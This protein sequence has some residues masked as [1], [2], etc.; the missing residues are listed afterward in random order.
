MKCQICGFEGKSL[1]SH[2]KKHNISVDE[3]KRKYNVEKVHTVPESQKKY[4][5][6]L[7]KNRM[8][9]KKWKDKFSKSRVSI[10]D[11]KYWIQ[12]GMEESDAIDMVKKIQSDNA[13]KRDYSKSP[14]VLSKEFYLSKG[15]TI[16]E[17]EKAISEI[18][19]KL[20]SNSSKFSGK[21]HSQK[22][23][24]KISQSIS[25]HIHKIG[26]S[27]WVS[28]FGDLSE[29]KYKSNGEIEIFNYVNNITENCVEAN[30]FIENYNVDLLYKNKIIDYFGVYW[31]CHP[32]FYKDDYFHRQKNKFAY[33]IRDEDNKRI[34]LLQEMGYSVMIVWENDYIKNKSETL[35]KVK[36]F[37]YDS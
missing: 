29:P 7:W 10:W 32:D 23:K 14:T 34:D 20:S 26:V 18:Q 15:F 2:L 5:S 19:S 37:I 1:V 36:Q 6:D 25:T 12:K 11:Y 24:E 31:H 16:E 22:S 4:L 9:D 8:K 3:Y 30:V 17:A 27:D 35:N 21:K 13:R 33:E 28:H